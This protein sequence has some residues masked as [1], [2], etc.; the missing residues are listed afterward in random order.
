[1]LVLSWSREMF[2]RF[3]LD[4]MMESFARGHV[5]GFE[6]LGAVLER[7]GDHIRFHPRMLELAGH[8]HF[9]PRPCAPRRGNERSGKRLAPARRPACRR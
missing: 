5:E 1:V 3:Y 8:Y 7:V 6:A 4:Q 2:A 9:A